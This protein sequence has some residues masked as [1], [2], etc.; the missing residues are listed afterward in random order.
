[1]L[2]WVQLAWAGFEL[3][4][5]VVIGTNC[6]GSYKSNYHMTTMTPKLFIA[7]FN[8]FTFGFCPQAKFSYR[9]HASFFFSSLQLFIIYTGA[10]WSWW[11]GSWI[12]NLLPIQLVPFTTKVSSNP[13][14]GE[15][16]SIQH[17]VIKFVSD[18]WQV[19]VFLRKL[20]FPPPIKL[21]VNKTEILLKVV[22]NT[23]N[24]LVFSSLQLQ[25]CW[26]K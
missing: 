21:T 17:Y 1:M 25:Q 14:H 6:I 18:L 13:V 26:I 19:G 7:Y 8:W 12:Y 23:I 5:L 10:L 4:T 24:Q 20:W 3:T 11:Y 22:L 16:Y 2:Y 15:V 9:D